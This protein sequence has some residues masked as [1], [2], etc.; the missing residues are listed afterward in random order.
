MQYCMYL[1]K[2]RS[3]TEAEERGEGETLARHEKLLW[4]LAKQQGLNITEIYREIV[5]G[6]T[7]TARP[8][9]QRLLHDVEQGRWDGVLVVEIERLARGD[10]IDQ[11]LV[12]QTFKLS[13]TKIITP[14]K[15]YDPQNEFDEEYFEFGLFMSRR[16]Y[17]TINRRL[18]RGRVASQHEGKFISSIPPYGY[19]RVK[20][21][22]EKGFTLTPNENEASTIRLIFD[23]YTRGAANADGGT[24]RI[25]IQLIVRKLNELGVPTRSGKPWSL[26]S[27]RDM[28]GNP[29][30]IGKIRIKGK[31]KIKRVIDGQ[32]RNNYVRDY[33][34]AEVVDGRHPAIVDEETYKLAQHY[35]SKNHS[36]PIPTRYKVA[37]PL[38]GLVVCGECGKHMNR[39]PYAARGQEDTLICPTVGCMNVSSKLRLVEAK[40]LS[41]LQA[42][43]DRYYLEWNGAEAPAA[44]EIDYLKKSLENIS[45]EHG[46]LQTQLT[47]AYDLLEQGVYSTDIFLERSRTLTERIKAIEDKNTEL[48]KELERQLQRERNR[49]EIIP[50]I[51]HLL[52]VYST[53][54][55]PKDKNEMLKEVIE[56][57]LYFKREKSRKKGVTEEDFEV[58]IYPRLPD[59]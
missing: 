51:E 47:K 13:G 57:V 46:T 39:R 42:L 56:K 23:W 41:S 7:I 54:G 16:E 32:V 8:E 17:K 14:V 37:S 45:K 18:Q 21:E 25:G 55:T 12:A 49:S 9:M 1:R 19:D 20:L 11:G 38:A 22:H 4:A 44:T 36:L 26:A 27:V 34:H 24:E 2:S 50:K 43:V 33:E 48:E 29:V 59:D 35:L 30:Y 58:V 10:T 40:I 52:S 28:L 6:D 31:R 15:T 53:L 5:S 3:D